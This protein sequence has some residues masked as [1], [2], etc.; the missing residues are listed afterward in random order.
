MNALKIP[1]K[2][3]LRLLAIVPA[4]AVGLSCISPWARSGEV[5]A[6]RIEHHDG[7]F[8]IHSDML[9]DVPVSK[10]RS[11]LNDFQNLPRINSDIKHVEHLPDS[12]EGH[13]RMRIRSEVCALLV[14][15]DYKWVQ[16][17][18]ISNASEILTRFDPTLSD[19]R[20]GWVRYRFHREGSSTRLIMDAKLEP[21]FWFPPLI[22]PMLIKGKLRDEALETALGIEE[23]VPNMIGNEKGRRF[24]WRDHNNR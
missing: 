2:Q 5:V 8:V 24:A 20:M 14:C 18:Q 11:L 21:D 1:T 13:P 3:T 4:V 7:Q 12:L 6:T 23:L 15:L 10:V 19:F 16:E 17:V 22:G 9:L